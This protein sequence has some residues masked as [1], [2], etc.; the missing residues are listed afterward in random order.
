MFLD[1]LW[2]D[3]RRFELSKEA[4]EAF[5]NQWGVFFNLLEDF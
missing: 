5:R 3:S 1:E 2:K 4:F